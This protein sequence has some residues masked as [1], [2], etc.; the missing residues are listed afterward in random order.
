[1]LPFYVADCRAVGDTYLN[2]SIIETSMP[3][4]LVG[5]RSGRRHPYGVSQWEV[6]RGFCGISGK[7]VW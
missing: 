4:K 6:P 7:A 1:L 5:V 3:H 2:G